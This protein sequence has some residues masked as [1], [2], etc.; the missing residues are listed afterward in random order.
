MPKLLAFLPCEQ[1]IVS[2]E[3]ETVSLITITQGL[4]LAVPA[5][6]IGKSV[7]LPHRWT[8]FAYWLKERG[9]E[10]VAFEQRVEYVAPQNTPLLNQITQ[11]VIAKSTHSQI[12]R[13]GALPVQSV[14]VGQS[15]YT[16]RL[17][18]RRLGEQEFRMVSEFPLTLTIE[19]ASPEAVSH[20]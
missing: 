2:K 16:L 9:D 10:G 4:S 19:V 13:I 12:G 5:D 8:M 7:V 3:D 11:F 17:S 18:I 1:V 14:Q 20:K 6:A 15:V